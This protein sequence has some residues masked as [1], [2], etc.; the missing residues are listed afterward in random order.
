MM[1]TLDIYQYIPT[2]VSIALKTETLTTEGFF[3]ISQTGQKNSGDFC[4]CSP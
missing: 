4:F 2:I 1:K 3:S